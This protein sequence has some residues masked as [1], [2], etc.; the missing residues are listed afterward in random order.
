MGVSYRLPEQHTHL[1]ATQVTN[2]EAIVT[3][4]SL[5]RI[6]DLRRELR[7]PHPEARPMMRW[8]WFGPA[9]TDAGIGAEL[10]S[11]ADAGLGGAEISF[12]YPW[13]EDAEPYGTPEM[14]RHVRHAADVAARL[15]LR[16]DVTLGSG[17]SF[18]GS[19]IGPEHAARTLA[20]ERQDAS[21]AAIDVDVTPR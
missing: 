14:Y 17:W 19:H 5:P 11:M 15:G 3:T 10:Q 21:P 6:G 2:E 12:V 20:W 13:G 9:V 18:G 7:R 4:P 8:W 1:V 16:L